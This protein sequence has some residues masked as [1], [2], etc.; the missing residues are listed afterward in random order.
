MYNVHCTIMYN[1]HCTIMYNVHCTIMYNVHAIIYNVHCTI[2]YNVHCTIIMYRMIYYYYIEQYLLHR[3]V[4][5]SQSIPRLCSK[6]L[7]LFEYIHIYTVYTI[8]TCIVYTIHCIVYSIDYTL[9]TTV[10]M[11]A[12]Y[13]I[14]MN[15]EC[16]PKASIQTT[17]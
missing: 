2:M 17:Q 5:T 7:L 3:N 8:H 16:I 15:S 9:Y 13:C 12:M 14:E 10:Y 11:Y 1:V 4:R 6:P